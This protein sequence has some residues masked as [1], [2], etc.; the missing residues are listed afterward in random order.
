MADWFSF[1]GKSSTE[2]GVHVMSFPQ[3]PI[4]EVRADFKQI[5]GRSGSLTILEGEDVYNDVLLSI[6]CF[7]SDLSKL[8]QISSWL[9]GVNGDSGLIRG[10][11]PYEYYV[12]RLVNQTDLSKIIRDDQHRVFPAV[13]RCKPYRYVYP[14]ITPIT[15]VNGGS[16]TNPG[17]VSSAPI[18]V[19]SGSGA[20]D[21]TVGD[22]T[23]SISN[24]T[25]SI[26]IDMDLR[27]AYQTG[28][29]PLIPMTNIVSKTDWPFIIP[30]GENAISWTGNITAAT[31]EP[32]WRN[33]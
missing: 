30:P 3:V 23:I 31:I 15:L 2:L 24:L 1:N 17:N 5:L 6:T 26:T 29:N 25:G 22:K 19:I 13:F 33:V 4:P 8:N 21:L 14:A 32:R 18:Y 11:R 28:S 12:G 16:I 9:R 20:I 27:V 7:V 10:D